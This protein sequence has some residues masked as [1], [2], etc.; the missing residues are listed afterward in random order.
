[1]TAVVTAIKDVKPT[2]ANAPSRLIGPEQ[3]EA[4]PSHA[5]RSSSISNEAV[6]RFST[7]SSIP[8]SERSGWVRD[9]AREHAPAFR[10]ALVSTALRA[11]SA[12]SLRSLVG[13]QL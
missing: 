6:P 4:R 2:N 3:D 10:P 8:A 13:F 5:T 1:M 9:H 7:R 11:L 12:R